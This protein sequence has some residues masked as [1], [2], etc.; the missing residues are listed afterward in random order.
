MKYIFVVEWD[1]DYVRSCAQRGISC[2]NDVINHVRVKYRGKMIL[3]Q[4]EDYYCQWV[5]LTLTEDE[6]HSTYEEVRDFLV[7]E[8]DL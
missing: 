6:M 1:K 7:E 5:A 3:A 2:V 8:Y 4:H